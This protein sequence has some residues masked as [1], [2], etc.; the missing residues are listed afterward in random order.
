MICQFNLQFRD[1]HILTL[2]SELHLA[3]GYSPIELKVNSLLGMGSNMGSNPG[4]NSMNNQMGGRMMSQQMVMEQQQKLLQQQQMFRNQHQVSVAA[5]QQQQIVRPPPPDYKTSAGM[6][7]P[8]YG[9]GMRRMPHQP[10]P[11]SGK[12]KKVAIILSLYS[13]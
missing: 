4:M 5:M 2:L 11:P 12:L 8:R 13:N 10:I 9:A 7:Q 6:M 3:L 1:L